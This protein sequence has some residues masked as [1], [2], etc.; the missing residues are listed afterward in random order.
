MKVETTDLVSASDAA[1]MLG[2]KANVISNWQKRLDFPAPVAV[3]ANGKIRLFR[4][5]DVLDWYIK[6]LPPETIA[7]ITSRDG[8]G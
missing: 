3:V 4:K 8:S 7:A 5:S 6:R 2:V 1:H